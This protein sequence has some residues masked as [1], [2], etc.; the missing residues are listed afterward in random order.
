VRVRVRAAGVAA[1][2][3]DDQ[4]TFNQLLWGHRLPGKPEPIYPVRNATPDG[5]TIFDGLTG[6][7]T[8]APLPADAI[9]SVR[10]A[11]DGPRDLDEP[12]N[13]THRPVELS[14]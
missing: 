1:G 3:V 7:R 5:L 9:C 2:A 6:V 10:P 4:L 11:T 14:S 8:I 12:A 13:G